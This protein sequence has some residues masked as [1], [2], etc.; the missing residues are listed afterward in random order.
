MNIE[1][2][3]DLVKVRGD[4]R[5][6]RARAI[7][8]A[9]GLSQAEIARAVGVERATVALWEQGRRI[10]HGDPALAYG[11]LLAEL[12]ARDAGTVPA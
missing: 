4:L 5:S 12:A 10:P 7:R 3:L 6:G 11:R 9:V 2:A 1:D 8:E